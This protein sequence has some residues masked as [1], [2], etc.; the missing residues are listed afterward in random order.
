M[1][2]VAVGYCLSYFKDVDFNY[3][4]KC[5]TM[6]LAYVFMA[7]Y[8]YKYALIDLKLKRY[9]NVYLISLLCL[10][11]LIS[12]WFNLL[13][14]NPEIYYALIDIKQGDGLSWRLIYQSVE[15]LCFFMVGKDAFIHI[16]SKLIC[17]GGWLSV[18]IKHNSNTKNGR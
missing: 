7:V 12:G 6:S 14:S 8:C 16:R 10:C 13:F 3:H 15:L 2:S 5:V 18:I 17:G 9:I 4:L 1:I 11:M